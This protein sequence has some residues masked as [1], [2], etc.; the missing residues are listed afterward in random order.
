[1]LSKIDNVKSDL[2]REIQT[3]KQESDRK[4]QEL[5]RG[6]TKNSNNINSVQDH[7][8][9]QDAKLDQMAD[10]ISRQG[11]VI[12]ELKND[13]RVVQIEKLRPNLIVY[14]IPENKSENLKEVIKTIFRY[15]NVH[16]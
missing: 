12:R 15:S 16:H 3:T 7:N 10:T 4:I 14:G 5:Q 8:K 2:T 9:I 13:L 11:Q 1:M 6:I